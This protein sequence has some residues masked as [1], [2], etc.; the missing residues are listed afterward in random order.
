VVQRQVEPGVEM[1]AGITSDP[2][3]GPLVACGAGGTAVELIGD[4]AVRLAP[5]SEPEAGRMVRSLATFPLL[6][7]YR[8]GPRADVA[9]FEKVL[10]RLGALADAH[11]EVIEL[12]LNPVVVGSGGA[13]VVDARVRVEPPRPLLPW[14][15]VGAEAPH[16]GIR[17]S[18]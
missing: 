18:P 12:D 2:Q 1:L 3:L 14:P 16:L 6:D 17:T 7:G 13:V 8:G 5:L 15:A 10:T 11:P 4:V 9:A